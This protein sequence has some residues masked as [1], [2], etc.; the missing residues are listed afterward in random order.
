MGEESTSVHIPG[1]WEYHG[2]K[3]GLGW[4]QLKL[5]F[6]SPI[7]HGIIFVCLYHIFEMYISIDTERVGYYA[8]QDLVFIGILQHKSSSF[9]LMRRR[10]SG[11]ACISMIELCGVQ[12]VLQETCFFFFF[13]PTIVAFPA[14]KVTTK[15]SGCKVGAQTVGDLSQP[16]LLVNRGRPNNYLFASFPERRQASCFKLLLK[17]GKYRDQYIYLAFLE[18]V[19]KTSEKPTLVFKLTLNR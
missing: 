15:L 7:D 9:L 17:R 6:R 19:T 3:L 18:V 5:M 12:P 13:H 4:H 16:L 11:N 2:G 1:G 14:Q 8:W 10:I